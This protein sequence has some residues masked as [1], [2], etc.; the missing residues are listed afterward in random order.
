MNV[1]VVVRMGAYDQGIAGVFETPEEADKAITE[2]K[3]EEPDNYHDF[4]IR[5]FTI[6]KRNKLTIY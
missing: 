1:F 3:A 2:A 5:S 4:E 6:G